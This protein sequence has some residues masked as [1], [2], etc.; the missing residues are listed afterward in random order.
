[1]GTD[2]HLGLPVFDVQPLFAANIWAHRP[3]QFIVVNCSFD[4]TVARARLLILGN[5][6]ADAKSLVMVFFLCCVFT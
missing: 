3:F 5:L 1:M 2:L 6:F 4:V